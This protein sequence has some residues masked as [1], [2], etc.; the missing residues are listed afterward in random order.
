MVWLAYHTAGFS[1]SKR[2]P[3]YGQLMAKM[4]LKEHKLQTPDEMIRFV[5]MMNAALGGK[6]LRKKDMN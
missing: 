4:G 2:M 3:N 5:E 1:R 6:D